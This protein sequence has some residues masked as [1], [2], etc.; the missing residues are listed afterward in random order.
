[1][2]GRPWLMSHGT[3]PISVIRSKRRRRRCA[4]VGGDLYLPI[5]YAKSC[6]IT[7]DQIP[8]YYHFQYRAYPPGTEVKSFTMG[9][10]EAAKPTIE[11]VSQTLIATPQPASAAPEKEQ[12]IAPGDEFAIDLPNGSAA[13]RE[14]LVQLDPKDA[15]QSSLDRTHRNIRQRAG[16]LV[17]SQRIL[18]NRSE[19]APSSG[20]VSNRDQRWNSRRLDGSCPMSIRRAWRSRMWAQSR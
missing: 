20:L 4:G 12:T 3:R 2:F 17:P 11:K 10:F 8:F 16:Y 7:L 6:K 9:E 5:A 14:I 13:V 1:M 19:I 18:R 15:A